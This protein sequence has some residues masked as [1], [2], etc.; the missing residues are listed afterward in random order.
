MKIVYLSLHEAHLD[1]GRNIIL[2]AQLI[3]DGSTSV[4][5]VRERFVLSDQ[6]GGAEYVVAVASLLGACLNRVADECGQKIT[7]GDGGQVQVSGKE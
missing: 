4:D 7:L 1:D 6:C 5:C 3:R 2:D